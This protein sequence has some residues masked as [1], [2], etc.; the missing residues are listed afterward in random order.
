MNFDVMAENYFQSIGLL[1]AGAFYKDIQDFI[2]ISRQRDFNDDLVTNY[3]LFQPRNGAN[4]TL[5]GFEV[6][7]QR[8]LDFLP[9]IWKGLGIYANYTFT[10]SDATGI[11]NEDGELRDDRTALPGTTPHMFNASL[12]FETEKLVLRASI[13]YADAY[14]DELGDDPFTDRYYDQQLFIDINGSYAFTPQWRFFVEVNNLTN[15]P[16]RFYQG[17]PE[18]TMQVEYY[19]VRMNAGIKFD[20]FG[21]DD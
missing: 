5:Y 1:S 17:V 6:A 15:Q 16:L 10:E 20:I 19:N 11:S 13:N 7:I 12:S 4:A 3:D 8:Q 14:V 9:G 2:F 18:Q 21:S